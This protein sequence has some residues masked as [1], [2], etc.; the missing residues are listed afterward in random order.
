MENVDISM[1]V[2]LLI[3]AAS[4]YIIFKIGKGIL[5]TILFFIVIIASLGIGF[6][7]WQ[8]YSFEQI[9]ALIG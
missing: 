2:F 3:V 6:M 9:I 8:G 5:K 4:S 7:L 1:P